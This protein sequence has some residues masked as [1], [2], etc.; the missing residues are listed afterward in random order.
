MSHESAREK[1][2]AAL[3]EEYAVIESSATNTDA[4]PSRNFHQNQIVFYKSQGV[5]ERAKILQVHLDD[6]L[7]PFY[8]I[9]LLESTKEKQTDSGHL[10]VYSTEAREERSQSKPKQKTKRK[11]LLDFGKNALKAFESK[12]A[13]KAALKDVGS[14]VVSAGKTVGTGMSKVTKDVGSVVVSAGKAVGKVTKDIGSG[15]VSA[16]KAV[17]SGVKSGIAEVS[18]QFE[19][20]GEISM[21]LGE[22]KVY[23]QG[24]KLEGKIILNLVEDMQAERV[25]VTLEAAR[26]RSDELFDDVIWDDTY[27]ISGKRKYTANEEIEFELIIPKITKKVS[28]LPEALLKGIDDIVQ[29][30]DSFTPPMWIIHAGFDGAGGRILP[31]QSKLYRLHVNDD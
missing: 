7:V 18:K 5:K 31:L 16:G 23:E 14:G 21:D 2:C 10:E 11:S 8:T 4:Q 22:L 19:S 27:E 29:E 13:M 12:S 1:Q 9:L 25:T 26:P 28:S 6:D 17:E 24:D 20:I 30:R 15:V 3:L